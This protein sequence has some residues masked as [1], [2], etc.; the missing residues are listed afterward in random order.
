MFVA[1]AAMCVSASSALA[2]SVRLEGLLCVDKMCTFVEYD[3]RL[4]GGHQDERARMLI[5]LFKEVTALND[6]I[7]QL[8]KAEAYRSTFPYC[9][10]P[11]GLYWQNCGSPTVVG[12]GR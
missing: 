12:Q 9:F 6:V 10:D 1:L 8:E 3:A 2:Q 5:D 4:K 7:A 11:S